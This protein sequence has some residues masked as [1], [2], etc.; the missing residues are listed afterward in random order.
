[1]Y[2]DPVSFNIPPTSNKLTNFQFIYLRKEFFFNVYTYSLNHKIP[3]FKETPEFLLRL[4][5]L[6]NK[7]ELN[8]F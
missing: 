5:L 4:K 1:M 3:Y 6:E 7:I 8:L 2:V